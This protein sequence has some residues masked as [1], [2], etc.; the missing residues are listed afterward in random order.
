MA[1]V[2][3]CPRMDGQGASARE[4]GLARGPGG[5]GGAHMAWCAGRRG[6]GPLRRGGGEGRVG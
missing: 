3:G 4:E 1:V 5:E 2:Q 6:P